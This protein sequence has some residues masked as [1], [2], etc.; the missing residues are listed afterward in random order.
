MLLSLAGCDTPSGPTE[1]KSPRPELASRAIR[2]E[3]VTAA[4]GISFIH[5]H[6]GTGQKYMIE[7]LGSGVCLLDFDSD[8]WLDIYFV[9]AGAISA[10]RPRTQTTGSILYR[11]RG[12]GTFENVTARA[13]L[14]GTGYGMGCTAADIEN[15]G[16][17]D[18][19]VT[20]FGRNTLYRNNGDGTFTDVTES[21]GVGDPRWGT[22]A[23]F[24]DYDNDSLPDLY[25]VNY[26][27]FSLANNVYCGDL[28][29]GYRTYCHP[30]TFNGVPDVLYHNEGGGRFR[31]VTKQAGVYDPGGKGLG[32][33]WGD[34]DSDGWQDLYVANDSTPN[35]LYHNNGNGTF[36]EIGQRAGVALGEEGL[37]RAGMGIAVGDCDQDGREDLFVTNLSQEPN[38]LF[39]N[40]GSD[41]FADETYPSGLGSP[42]LLFLGFGTNFLDADLD[43]DLD[44]FVSNGHILDNVELYSDSI[45]YRETPFLF[46]NLGPC[47]FRDVS[48]TSGP[49]F[50]SKDVGRGSAVG[51]LDHDG[52]A[53]L[54]VSANN[55]PAHVLLNRTPRGS[56]HWIALGLSGSRARDALGTRVELV[57]RGRSSWAQVRSASSYLSQGDLVLELGLG[58]ATAVERVRV[59]WSGGGMEE[60]RSLAAD[61]YYHIRQGSGAAEAIGP[62]AAW[63]R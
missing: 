62:G 38:S 23:A 27:D 2:F 42:S 58:D 3:D 51:D 53:D 35:F 14:G 4:A 8:G 30:K 6:G 36:V 10:D 63:K 5:S 11:N 48:S 12:D 24:G 56:R 52:A 57:A 45:T 49:Y 33:V 15:D 47:R 43:S 29:P 26:V 28:K 9:Q 44:I 61:H 20:A 22:S 32:V 7:T 54:V 31:D 37:P 40:L 34:F 41:L 21:A 18:L 55:L 50:L 25:V 46:E 60:I 19:Y 13:G 59:W 16:D 17:E 1:Q 39:R